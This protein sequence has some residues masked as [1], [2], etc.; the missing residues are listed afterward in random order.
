MNKVLTIILFCILSSN[1]LAATSYTKEEK[2][3]CP[4]AVS[5]DSLGDLID[6]IRTIVKSESTTPATLATEKV[7]IESSSIRVDL[8]KNFTRQELLDGPLNPLSIRYWLSGD[9]KLAGK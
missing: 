3:N 9:D 6:G 2:S 1:A 8:D 4:T 7:S 5:Y